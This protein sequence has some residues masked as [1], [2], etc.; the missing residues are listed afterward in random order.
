MF[1]HRVGLR[2]SRLRK[3][4]VVFDLR[5]LPECLKLNLPRYPAGSRLQSKV[6]ALC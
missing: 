4:C 1:C 6:N 3:T 2:L 5:Y